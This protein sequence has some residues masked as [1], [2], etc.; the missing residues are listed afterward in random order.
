ML[1]KGM[2]SAWHSTYFTASTKLPNVLMHKQADLTGVGTV[3][4]RSYGRAIS[5]VS[6]YV[7]IEAD[8]GRP[9]QRGRGNF[10][11]E[12]QDMC[13]I[14]P[15]SEDAGGVVLRWAICQVYEQQPSMC[16][17]Q[18]LVVDTCSQGKMA[19]ACYSLGR[20]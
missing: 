15:V 13:K 19:A 5:R 3:N 12:V 20:Y 14:S 16:D 11:A 18:L 9:G 7:Q 8:V 2:P 1:L 10:V 4:A 6:Y 17:G